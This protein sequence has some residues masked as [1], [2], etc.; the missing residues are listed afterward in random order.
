[1][2]FKTKLFLLTIGLFF[3]L[4]QVSLAEEAREEV[5]PKRA[6]DLGQVVVTATKT[7]RSI[8]TVASSVTLITREEI[9]ESNAKNVFDLLRKTPGVCVEDSYGIGIQGRVSLRGFDPFGSKYVAVLVDGVPINEGDD[10]D[11]SWSGAVPS[12]KN[13]ERIEVVKGP[14]SALYGGNSMGGVINIITKSGPTKPEIEISSSYGSYEALVE[15]VSAGGT[16]GKLNYQLGFTYKEGQGY[17]RH[18]DYDQNNFSTKLS[19]VF[20]SQS[21][22]TV[23][24]HASD[25]FYKLAG[26]LTQ[27]Q[28]EA[29]RKQANSDEK[30]S[31]TDMQVYRGDITYRTEINDYSSL[32]TTL[33]G[34]YKEYDDFMYFGG[35]KEYVSDIETIGGELQ[36]NLERKLFG[37]PNS[38]LLGVSLETDDVDYQ[39]YKATGGI[40]GALQEDNNT[41]VLTYAVFAQDELTILE[42]LTISLGGRYDRTEYDFADYY[43]PA[44]SGEKSFDKFSPKLGLVYKLIDKISLFANISQAFKAPTAGKLFSGSYANPNLDSEIATNYELGIKTQPWD[45]LSFQLSGYWMDVDD[46]IITVALGG[47]QFEYQNTGQTCHKGIESELDLELLAGLTT[48]LSAEYQNAK[49][50][51][52]T[53]S[54]T[55]YEGNRLPHAPKWRTSWG[56]RYEHPI[57]LTYNLELNFVDKA[58][59]DRA[60]QYKIPSYAVWN[61]R[62]DYEKGWGSLYLAVKNIFNEDYYE[63]RT[64]SGAIYP[65]P[66]TTFMA[67]ASLKF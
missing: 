17:R 48:Y 19:Y 54:G 62:L 65:S 15:Q 51:D 49:F 16:V 2:R 43:T 38:L 31:Y 50:T 39:K 21:D 20:N 53:Y 10:G 3:A 14:T 44:E 64:S 58:Y 8:G 27:T 28:Y 37:K 40:R 34:F 12:L 45:F 36:Y 24:F 6:F 55:S 5:R 47:G 18:N 26:G 59:A 32:K 41:E 9:E 33:Y 57:G 7:E 52:Y 42:P 63:N 61:L 35:T 56:L 30:Y 25:V 66:P 4:T 11:V 23:N 29:D 46:E 22:L 13:I 60:N 1:M 67:G